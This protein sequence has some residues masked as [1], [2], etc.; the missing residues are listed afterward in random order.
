[1][2]SNVM[3]VVESCRKLDNLLKNVLEN[4]KNDDERF[5]N[6]NREKLC[7]INRCKFAII[8][9]FCRFCFLI[10]KDLNIIVIARLNV[11]HIKFIVI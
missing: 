4:F 7:V 5:E 3:N 8:N 1:M 9:D 2:I 11:M 6:I 10:N